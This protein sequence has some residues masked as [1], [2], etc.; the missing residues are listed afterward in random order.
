MYTSMSIMITIIILDVKY[1]LLAKA[2]A[3]GRGELCDAGRGPDAGQVR[4]A[5]ASVGP[6]QR[7]AEEDQGLADGDDGQHGAAAREGRGSLQGQRAGGRRRD[8]VHGRG[9]AVRA[10]ERPSAAAG[11][12]AQRADQSSG[13]GGA[14]HRLE[15]R[16]DGGAPER[17]QPRADL[18]EHGTTTTT[19]T[20]A[21]TATTTATA[22]A[23]TTTYNENINNENND[24]N[25]N[26]KQQ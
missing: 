5:A 7:S 23:A 18:P 11:G 22:A 14:H 15:A 6:R 24:N 21:T 25:N 4:A 1:L 19:T 20:T 16:A 3:P 17:H 12:A 13:P 2:A 10:A 9:P 8:H 26:D